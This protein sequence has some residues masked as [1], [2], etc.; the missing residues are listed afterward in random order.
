MPE[1]DA[2]EQGTDL[3]EQARERLEKTRDLKT[4]VFIYLLVNAVLIGI[5]AVATPMLCLADPS[6]PRLGHR[7]CGQ[8]LGRVRSQADRRLR[9]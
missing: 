9:D 5:W 3:R 8:C 4:H 1:L 6:D 7:R 2:T